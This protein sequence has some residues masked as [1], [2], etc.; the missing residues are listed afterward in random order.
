MKAR[1]EREG[2]GRRKDKKVEEVEEGKSIN[3]GVRKKA[4]MGEG[5]KEVREEEGRRQNWREG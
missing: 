5:S 3:L 1:Q 2:R 4:E